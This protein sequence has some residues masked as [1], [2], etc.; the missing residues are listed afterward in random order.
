MNACKILHTFK[1]KGHAFMIHWIE[2]KTKYKGNYLW[3]KNT[4]N[5]NKNQGQNVN[6][7]RNAESISVWAIVMALEGLQWCQALIFAG[8]WK[9]LGRGK[10]GA[11]LPGQWGTFR[12]R[13]GV[14]RTMTTDQLVWSYFNILRTSM[15]ALQC[16]RISALMVLLVNGGNW[17]LGKFIDWDHFFHLNS[18]VL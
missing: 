17:K 10:S 7:L 2:S 3:E 14:S 4:F 1:S 15:A 11:Q 18:S 6:N 13:V 9:C 5:T 12:G 8:S 16:S